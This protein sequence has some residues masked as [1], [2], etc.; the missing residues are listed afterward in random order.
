SSASVSVPVMASF[1]PKPLQFTLERRARVL[2]R[3][4]P[5]SLNTLGVAAAG[6]VAIRPQPLTI[7]SGRFSSIVCPCCT[8]AE[9]NSF[10]E[11]TPPHPHPP[12]TRADSPVRLPPSCP[13][14]SL[15][16]PQTPPLTRVKRPALNSKRRRER[17]R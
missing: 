1:S 15:A 4:K 11:S 12:R 14:T 8:I 16:A 5:A 9:V 2:C 13:M 7:A 3:D 6:P 10:H 17:G